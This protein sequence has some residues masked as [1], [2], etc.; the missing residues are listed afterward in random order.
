MTGCQQRRR[1]RH[2]TAEDLPSENQQLTLTF[3]I[4]YVQKDDSSEPVVHPI[5]KRATKLHTETCNYEMGCA[6]L[7]A[8]YNIGDTITY[9]SLGTAGTL[10]AGDSFDCD[11]NGDGIFNSTNERF[12]YVSPLDTDNNYGVLIYYNNVSGGEPNNVTAFAY[13]SSNKPRENGPATAAQQLPTTTQWK[14]V[15]LS[16]T[17]RKI[18][19]ETGTE[20]IDFSY[21]GYSARLLT[22]NEV[23]SACGITVGSYTIGELDTCKYLLENTKYSSNTPA[24]GWWLE[25]PLSYS[26]YVWYVSGNFRI[27]NLG[28]ASRSGDYGAR[29]VIEVEKS[30]IKY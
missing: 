28:T 5:C 24:Y 21:E 9:G 7:G 8:G 22:T 23:E 10:A 25:N 18:K 16:N 26:T 4:E 2:I 29:P 19:D 11:V 6:Y 14:N 3:S 15:R 12:Y 13:D 20:Y 30:K 17:T 27:V 1:F